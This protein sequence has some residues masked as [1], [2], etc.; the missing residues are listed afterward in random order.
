MIQLFRHFDFQ[1]VN[2]SKPWEEQSWVNWMHHKM[3]VRI[4]EDEFVQT[5]PHVVRN[6]LLGGHFR[7]LGHI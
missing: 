2:P 5:G 1:I 7:D 4:T 6:E 3:M